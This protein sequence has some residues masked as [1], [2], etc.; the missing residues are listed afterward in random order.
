MTL[1]VIAIGL[2]YT[3]TVYSLKGC[4]NDA[5]NTCEMLKRRY[6]ARKENVYLM[7]DDMTGSMFPSAENVKILLKDII[8]R[9]KS[10]DVLY[11]HISGHGF[12]IKGGNGVAMTAAGGKI[13]AGLNQCVLLRHKK[14]DKDITEHNTMCDDQFNKI[15]ELVP[16]RMKMFAVIDTCNSGNVFELTHN[17]RVLGKENCPDFCPIPKDSEL[18][19]YLTHNDNRGCY[20]GDIV[21][22]SSVKTKQVAWDTTDKKGKPGGAFTNL[23]L[24]LIEKSNKNVTP[25]EL[26]YKL[27]QEIN[28]KYKQ[29]P[30][31]SCCN[32][33]LINQP[34]LGG[35]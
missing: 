27:D 29:D 23:F 30:C 22:I 19:Y 32:I 35:A 12:N 18:S 2:N 10:T 8:K 31:L 13:S 28:K 16:P 34:F 14:D 4:I 21:I 3:G 15:L 26:L 1:W 6:G 33:D 20:R 24:E 9:T 17:I 5:R 11:L 7:T 25:L